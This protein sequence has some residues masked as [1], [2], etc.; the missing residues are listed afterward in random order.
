MPRASKTDSPVAMDETEIEIRLGQLDDYAVTFETHKTDSDPAPLFVGL[1]DDSC[2]CTH[3]G[4]VV[5]GRLV[6]RYAD[7][8]ETVETGET[9]LARPGHRPLLFAGTELVEFTKQSELDQT[10]AV[11]SQ[12]LGAAKV[13][14]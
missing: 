7:H 5:K 8:D 14:G 13:G 2:Q 1:P 10:V 9:Y 11:I 3:L 12:N 4:Y 6:F